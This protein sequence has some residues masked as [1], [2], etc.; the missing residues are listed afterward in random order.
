MTQD[1]MEGKATEAMGGLKEKAGGMT[2]DQQTEAQGKA[3]QTEGKAEGMM[4]KVKD[5]ASNA[6]DKAKDKVGG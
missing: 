6:A 2:G 4:G 3:D 1:R 5:A